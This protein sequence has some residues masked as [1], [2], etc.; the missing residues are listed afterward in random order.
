LKL[1]REFPQR[2]TETLPMERVVP[3]L[4]RRRLGFFFQVRKKRKNA[5][6]VEAFQLLHM[7]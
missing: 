1:I 5:R 2:E 3:D 6:K 7:V 4:S